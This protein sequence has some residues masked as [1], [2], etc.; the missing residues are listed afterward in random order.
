MTLFHHHIV[1]DG[2]LDSVPW[3]TR[4]AAIAAAIYLFPDYCNIEVQKYNAETC[5][6]VSTYILRQEGHWI[7]EVS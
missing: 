6:L 4:Q 7:G 3:N 2:H 5:K 1:F